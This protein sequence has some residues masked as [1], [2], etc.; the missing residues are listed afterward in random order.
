[1]AVAARPDDDL[2]ER[3]VAWVVRSHG[4]AIDESWL[5]AHVGELLSAHKRPREVRFITELP[6][7]AI[8]KV[9]KHQLPHWVPKRRPADKPKTT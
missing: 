2:G 5:V 3:I 6:R 1:M 9:I 8:G 7:N 4:V